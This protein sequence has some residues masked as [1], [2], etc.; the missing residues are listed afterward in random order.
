[1]PAQDGPPPS[2][3][4]GEKNFHLRVGADRKEPRMS[5][6]GPRDHFPNDRGRN[7][8][9]SG[10][11][12]RPTALNCRSC[13]SK[14]MNLEVLCGR[15]QGL[16]TLNEPVRMFCVFRCGRHLSDAAYYAILICPRL[17]LCLRPFPLP[18]YC[19]S[20]FNIAS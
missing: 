1:M 12:L 3:R 19:K 8:R 2:R 6:L 14:A 11:R 16:G 13:A 18:L 7:F 20:P 5:E 17:S 15:R 10:R 9:G 4:R